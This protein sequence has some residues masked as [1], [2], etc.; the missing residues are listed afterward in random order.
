MSDLYLMKKNSE[1][2]TS[3]NEDFCS[4]IFPSF[5]FAPEQKETCGN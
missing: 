3:D 2:N 4:T 1:E 5:Q